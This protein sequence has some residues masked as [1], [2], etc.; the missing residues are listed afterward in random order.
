MKKLFIVLPLVVLLCFT[1]SCRKAEEVAEELSDQKK[2]EIARAVE[3]RFADYVDAMKKIDIERLLNFWAD[4]EGFVNA[5]DGLLTVGYDS[6]ANRMREFISNTAKVT[7]FEFSKPHVYVLSNDA[8]SLCNEY[9]WSLIDKDGNTVNAKGS[10]M[11][12]FKKFDGVWKVVH[13]AGTHNKEAIAELEELKAQAAVEDQNKALVI[14]WVKEQDKGNIDVFLDLFAPDFLYYDPSNSPNPM[15]KEETYEYLIEG[16]KLFQ[17]V[18]HILEEIIAVNDKVI[19]RTIYNFT[20]EGEFQGI[21]ITG[22]EAEFS[23]IAIF[24][25]RD[26]KIIEARE[27]VDKLGW[28]QQLGFELKPKEE[29]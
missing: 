19:V 11:Y 26:G 18:N 21:P 23:G 24:K 13:T 14:Q 20:H 10:W 28:F 9:E 6:L 29:G 17:E 2:E 8:A 25:I 12:V 22:K 16:A 1:F 7:S 27:E 15:S 5:G 3:E 4:T